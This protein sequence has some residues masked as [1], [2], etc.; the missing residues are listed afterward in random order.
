M[1]VCV[2]EPRQR[3]GLHIRVRAGCRNAAHASV[4]QEGSWGSTQIPQASVCHVT[5]GRV[6]TRLRGEGQQATRIAAASTSH[7]HHT[8][9]LSRQAV[10][11][12]MTLRTTPLPS[13]PAPPPPPDLPH[14][15]SPPSD[16]S[17]PDRLCRSPTPEA[18]C[19]SPLKAC[20]ASLHNVTA[21]QHHA[22]TRLSVRQLGALDVSVRHFHRRPAPRG[23]AVSPARQPPPPSSSPP[24]PKAGQAGQEGWRGREEVNPPCE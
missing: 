21:A 8:A 24:P 18:C 2:C 7:C 12:H 15:R 5:R 17:H 3:R 23:W 20:V 11:K 4:A 9:P 22:R 14:L 19:T 16:T 10:F 1:C 6:T 13:I